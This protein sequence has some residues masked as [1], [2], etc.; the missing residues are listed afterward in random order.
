MGRRSEQK[1]E[2][3]G[4]TLL[5]KLEVSTQREST[6]VYVILGVLLVRLACRLALSSLGFL[7]KDLVHIWHYDV[8]VV[9]V[10][11]RCVCPVQVRAVQDLYNILQRFLQNGSSSFLLR[12][13]RR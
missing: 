1:V 5:K 4:L 13:N 3:H 2:S 7:Q 11:V 9:G 6:F 12:Q 10:R 8:F